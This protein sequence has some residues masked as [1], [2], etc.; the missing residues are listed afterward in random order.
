MTANAAQR[1]SDVLQAIMQR[2]RL[3]IRQ[4]M[5]A[6]GLSRNSV[7]HILTGHTHQPS[8][9]TI[10]ALA[11]GVSTDPATRVL[12]P[13]LLDRYEA[14]LNGAAGYAPPEAEQART[15]I[16]MGMYYYCQSWPRARVL[17]ELLDALGPV[18]DEAVRR[19]VVRLTP[20]PESPIW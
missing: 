14:L 20:L 16:E 15:F 2:E 7:K 17:L 1:L 6:G 5:R 13:V 8:R 19:L 11:V 4:V 3:T 12:D 9:R 18:D 10:H